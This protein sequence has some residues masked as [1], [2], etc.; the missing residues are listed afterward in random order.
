MNTAPFEIIPA[1]RIARLRTALR[2]AEQRGANPDDEGH[3]LPHRA[4]QRRFALARQRA[5]AP[6]L[7][8]RAKRRR[9]A[10]FA[11]RMSRRLLR[12]TPLALLHRAIAPSM[13]CGIAA[14]HR[15]TSLRRCEL[16]RQ[17]RQGN[18]PGSGMKASLPAF[19]ARELSR[20]SQTLRQ[21]A[22]DR[23]RQRH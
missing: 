18:L 7:G 3:D 4:L 13:F 15:R 22:R 12:A 11:G 23:I 10:A 2:D 21:P 9:L 19:M 8:G 5:I 14:Y 16:N 20:S 1:W 6:R 17:I